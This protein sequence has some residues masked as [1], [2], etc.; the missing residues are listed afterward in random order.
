VPSCFNRFRVSR[1]FVHSRAACWVRLP[2]VARVEMP[3]MMV[4]WV[5]PGTIRVVRRCMVPSAILVEA[6]KALRVAAEELLVVKPVREML[7]TRGS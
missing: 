3:A 7:S 2:I 1:H 5:T 4:S 6:P